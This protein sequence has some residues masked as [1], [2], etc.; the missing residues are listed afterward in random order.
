MDTV[1]CAVIFLLGAV[2]TEGV[3]ESRSHPE[4]LGSSSHLQ[5]DCRW[6]KWE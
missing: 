2:A 5:E 6:V 3:W 4:V 1:I